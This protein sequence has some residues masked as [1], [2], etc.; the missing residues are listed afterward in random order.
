MRIITLLARH[1]TSKY[2]DAVEDCDALFTRQLPDVERELLIVDNSLPTEYEEHLSRD[3]ILIGASDEQREFSS[4]DRGISYLGQRIYDYDLVHLATSAF[5]V[6]Y[7][8]Y[9]DRFDTEMLGLVRGRSAVVGH[10]DY[11]NEP[12]TLLGRSLQAWV[13]SS[14]M[15]LP[16]EELA[17]L[18][19]LV[20][21]TNR[22]AFFCENPETPFRPDSPLSSN[23]RR[24][25]LDWLTGT[26]TGQGF[27][28]HSRFRLTAESFNFF[29]AKAAA[30]LNEQMLGVRLRAQG[31]ALVD[32]TWL[33]TRRR[34]LR[35]GQ[36][37]GTIPS[38]RRQVTT[39]DTDPASDK[40]MCPY[41][42]QS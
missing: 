24:Y 11:Y 22:E 37:L 18:G 13:R 19:S 35:A 25:I 15:F 17:L 32:A 14:F 3:R 9:L 6:L 33:A 42:L 12:V 20:S 23:Y 27:E 2:V 31:C 21:I 7:T 39:R 29:K 4:W 41:W 34:E 1:G 28:W 5:R 26:G 30:I 36:S 10:I 38:W 8:R 16:P 40:L